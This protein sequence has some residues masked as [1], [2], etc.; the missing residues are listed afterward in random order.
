MAAAADS[1]GG[2]YPSD[3]ANRADEA[4]HRAPVASML[5]LP[6]KRNGL[7]GTISV[8][9]RGLNTCMPRMLPLHHR[10]V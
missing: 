8:P 7:S 1:D 10:S 5:G 2:Y 9:F 3:I 4:V 6:V